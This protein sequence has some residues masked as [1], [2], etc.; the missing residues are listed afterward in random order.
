MNI[1]CYYMYNSFFTDLAQVTGVKSHTVTNNSFILEWVG[2]QG[3][4]D[5][6][7]VQCSNCSYTEVYRSVPK[8]SNRITFTDL[9]SGAMYVV[10]LITMRNG[11][12]DSEPVAFQASTCK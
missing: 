10:K 12:M 4:Y 8:T 3:Y 11:F 1:I 7:R 6:V 9:K 5:N 2:A